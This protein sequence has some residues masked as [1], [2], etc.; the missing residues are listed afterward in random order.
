MRLLEC[1]QREFLEVGVVALDGRELEAGSTGALFLV[2]QQSPQSLWK[3]ESMHDVV[4][5]FGDF[6]VPEE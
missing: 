1:P 4:N 2:P 3:L 6:L 5:P